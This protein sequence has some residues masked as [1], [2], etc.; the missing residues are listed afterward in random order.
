[1]DGY[2]IAA[3]VTLGGLMAVMLI[4]LWRR[5]PKQEG[6]R[7]RF[8]ERQIMAQGQAYR[9]GFQTGVICLVGVM[10]AGI[11]DDALDYSFF[12]ML[13]IVAMLMVFV[14]VAVWKDAYI[15]VGE[16][17]GPL[18]V[19]FLV[20]GIARAV[21]SGGDVQELVMAGACLY[22]AGLIW[23]RKEVREEEDGF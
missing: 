13:T 19:A 5:H 6:A 1:M 18:V 16:Q 21:F 8:D 20:M 11:F 15:A 23:A 14:T 10:I 4:W 17:E 7:Q 9:Y 3:L 22:V 12:L 2:G